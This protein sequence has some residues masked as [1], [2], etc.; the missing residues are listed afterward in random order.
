MCDI[1][2]KRWRMKLGFGFYR[3]SSSGE[4]NVGEY[5]RND[6]ANS[7]GM[8]VLLPRFL[9]LPDSTVAIQMFFC[10]VL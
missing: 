10:L 3:R 8:V 5:R 2:K 6:E 7:I 9:P 1:V 4:M